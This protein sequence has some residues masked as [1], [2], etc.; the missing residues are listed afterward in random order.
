MVLIS[1]I[2]VAKLEKEN[3]MEEHPKDDYGDFT[4]DPTRPSIY[5]ERT[6]AAV[7]GIWEMMRE[8]LT[9]V[10]NLDLELIHQ[11][12]TAAHRCISNGGKI[13]IC[14]CGGSAADAQHFAAELMGRFKEL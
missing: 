3:N 12:I 4:N 14:G 7:V 2:H 1:R 11:L 10:Q 6:N 8:H 9:A 13:M 5:G